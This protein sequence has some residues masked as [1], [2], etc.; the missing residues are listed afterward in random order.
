MT[1][2]VEEYLEVGSKSAA[3]LAVALGRCQVGEGARVLD[4]GCGLGRTLR[5]LRGHDWR[6]SGCDVHVAAVTWA[7]AAFPEVTFVVNGP[8]PPLPYPDASFEAIYAV[9]VFTHFDW[10]AQV[11]WANEMARCLACGGYLLVTTMGPHALGGFPNL[12]TEIRRNRL[13][14]EGFDF[15]RSGPNFNDNAAFHTSEGLARLAG[16]ELELESWTSGGLDGFQDLAILRRKRR[17]ESQP[18]TG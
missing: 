17:H 18:E 6:L 5:F 14:V 4:F 16:S 12:A 7:A 11:A 13:A 2:Y 3:S 8:S 9:S 1:P 10:E 15:V